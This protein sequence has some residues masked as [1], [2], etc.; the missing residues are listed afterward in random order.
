M[1]C[2]RVKISFAVDTPPACHCHYET[3]AVNWPAQKPQPA[4]CVSWCGSWTTRREAVLHAMPQRTFY[5]RKTHI[6]MTKAKKSLVI[7][8][9]FMPRTNMLLFDMCKWEITLCRKEESLYLDKA[10]MQPFMDPK[11]DKATN[12]GT[13]TEK[14]PITLSAKVCS[15]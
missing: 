15:G 11:Q 7:L 6:W 2:R 3:T 13:T 8:R 5:N 10:N 1:K 14:L 12:T 4:E 9:P